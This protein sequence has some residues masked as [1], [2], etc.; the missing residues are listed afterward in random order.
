MTARGKHWSKALA[1]KNTQ[2]A[3][4]HTDTD[5]HVEIFW[6]RAAN[7]QDEYAILSGRG[8]SF[9]VGQPTFNKTMS[10]GNTRVHVTVYNAV[11]PLSQIQ[12]LVRQAVNNA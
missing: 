6:G 8:R 4:Q 3:Y 11:L 10:D 7:G 12:T 2:R 9:I 1:P 5:M